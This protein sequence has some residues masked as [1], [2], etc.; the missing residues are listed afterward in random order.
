[1][2]HSAEDADNDHAIVDSTIVCAHGQRAG[3]RKRAPGRLLGAAKVRLSTIIDDIVDALG[4]PIGFHLSGGQAS[5]LGGSEVL[6][7]QMRDDILHADISL[8]Q[9]GKQAVILPKANRSLQ[10]EKDKEPYK[11]RHLIE[12]FFAELTL[13]RR[14][15]SLLQDGSKFS[16]R[17]PPRRS[18]LPAGLM[19]GSNG[20]IYRHDLFHCC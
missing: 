2:K 10:L 19:T 7:P 9:A 17:H 13:S 18:R 11:P 12:I 20:R 14:R 6:L 1:M 8:K 3:A 16:F 5:D 4:D 15:N